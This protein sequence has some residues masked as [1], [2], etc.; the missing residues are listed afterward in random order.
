MHEGTFAITKD[1]KTIYFTRN[2]FLKGKKKNG[3]KKINNLN[4]YKAELAR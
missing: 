4:I 3:S 1:R 2:N